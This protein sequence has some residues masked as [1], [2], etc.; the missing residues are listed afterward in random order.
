MADGGGGV[1]RAK[2]PELKA[3]DMNWAME[4]SEGL[5]VRKKGTYQDE[6]VAVKIW[7]KRKRRRAA[8][9]NSNHTKQAQTT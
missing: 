4:M 1:W 8:A 6:K 3:M 9:V 2:P 5:E 7:K